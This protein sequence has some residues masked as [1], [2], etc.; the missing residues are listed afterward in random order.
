MQQSS[1]IQSLHLGFLGVA[2]DC[3][4]LSLRRKAT[5]DCVLG[6]SSPSRWDA[7]K[8]SDAARYVNDAITFEQSEN[9]IFI[10]N[11][12]RILAIYSC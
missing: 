11:L 12:E 7:V 2:E 5:F 9:A 3:C 8:G 4:I 1:A 10:A 6:S